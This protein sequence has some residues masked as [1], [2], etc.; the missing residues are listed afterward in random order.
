MHWIDPDSLTPV[1]S[2]VARFLFNPHGDADGMLLTNGTEAHFPPHLSKKV[3]KTIQP[4]DAV[5]LYGVKPRA[6]DMIACIAIE[7]AKGERIDD[8]GPPAKAKKKK[9]AKKNGDAHDAG[10]MRVEI[11]DTIERT[12]HGPKGEVRGVLLSDGRIVRF[13]PHVAE[14]ARTL[15]RPGA[16]LAVR[17]EARPVSD[18]EVIEARALGKSKTRMK[19][20]VPKPPH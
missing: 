7:S 19:P 13:P 14:G 2:K 5:T 16:I 20:V 3:L 15:L 12:L 18:T 10:L 1:K 4:G 17:G 6:A 8:T 9:H 11:E